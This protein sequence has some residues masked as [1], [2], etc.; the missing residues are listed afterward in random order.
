M[1]VRRNT[2]F[3]GWY[4]LRSYELANCIKL[5][6]DLLCVLEVDGKIIGKMNIPFKKLSQ[7]RWIKNIQKDIPSK[8]NIGEYYDLLSVEW[9]PMRELSKEDEI[10]K[11]FS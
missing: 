3:K 8:I 5:K 11:Y 6:Q 9:K 1:I 2:L 7:K 10:K 4:D